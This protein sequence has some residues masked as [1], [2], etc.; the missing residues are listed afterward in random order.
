MGYHPRTGGSVSLA[1]VSLL[2]I[3]TTFL[4]VPLIGSGQEPLN[5]QLTSAAWAAFNKDDFQQAI[6]NADKCI[7]EFYLSA[8]REQKELEEKKVPQPA[9]GEI[10]GREKQVIL[11]RG[12]LND[13][14]T[15]LYI[16]GRAAEKQGKKV[17]ARDSYQKAI[18]LSYARCWDP[19]GWFWSPSQVAS[20]R[21]AGLDQ[22][23]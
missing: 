11:A 6:V 8:R 21:L 22:T 1:A 7:D 14:A 23:E 5:V 13:V 3:W 18:E 9:V 10:S 15:C 2:G 4:A 20:D 19:K 12:L 17:L 16:K